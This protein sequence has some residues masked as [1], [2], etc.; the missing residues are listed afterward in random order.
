[1]RR[2]WRPILVGAT[3]VAGTFALAHARV[4]EPPTSPAIAA[5][6]G[7]V[8]RGETVF[9]RNCS[10]CHGTGG[11][12]GGVGPRLVGAGLDVATVAATVQQGRGV[13]P[14]GLVSGRE[15]ADVVAYVVSI[16]TP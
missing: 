16:S 13:M 12:G 2:G 7:D 1:M 6:G 3:V 8:Y 11:V 14:A 10:S 9:Q 4:F 5:S 15:E